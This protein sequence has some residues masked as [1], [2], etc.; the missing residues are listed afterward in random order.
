MKKILSLAII[1]F[2]IINCAS[3]YA[4]TGY[5][6]WGYFQA[7]PGSTTW[8]YALTGPTTNIPDGSVEGWAFTFSGDEVPDAATPKVAPL[9]SKICGA[10]RSD[11]RFKR[12]ALVVDFGPASLRPKGEKLPHALV[13]CVVAQKNATGAEILASVAKTRNSSSGFICGISGYP[14]KECGVE[15]ETPRV[16]R[17]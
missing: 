4:S 11:S 9:F 17:K 14:E 6:Y 10:T 7:K 12:I 15:I 5:R 1:T 2:S 8:S 3:S 13:K 16:L